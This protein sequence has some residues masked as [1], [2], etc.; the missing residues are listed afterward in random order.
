MNNTVL[1]DFT[2]VS[3]WI[4]SS[5]NAERSNNLTVVSLPSNLILLELYQGT[6]LGFQTVSLASQM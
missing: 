3:K 4:K 6:A 1:Y 5:C 2:G